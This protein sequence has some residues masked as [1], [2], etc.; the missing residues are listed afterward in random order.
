[1][2][3]DCGGKTKVLETRVNLRR[4]EC[5]SCGSR[6]WTEEV[7]VGSADP[8]SEPKRDPVGLN[9]TNPFNV[10]PTTRRN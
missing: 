3:C 7:W 4:R 5:L 10:S 9:W 8:V 2:R 6:F 1:M